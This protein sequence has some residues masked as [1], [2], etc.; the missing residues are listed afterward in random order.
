MQHAD[1][2][3]LIG[4]GVSSSTKVWQVFFL[5]NI[6]RISARLWLRQTSA[7]VVVALDCC[8]KSA[9]PIQ[10]TSSDIADVEVNQVHLFSETGEHPPANLP[11]V[12]AEWAPQQSRSDLD[13]HRTYTNRNGQTFLK[14]IRQS[15][16]LSNNASKSMELRPIGKRNNA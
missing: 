14:T 6:L 5:I 15:S 9:A 11:E 8:S 13:K 7:G 10:V 16:S 2:D 1:V 12:F 3:P 4:S